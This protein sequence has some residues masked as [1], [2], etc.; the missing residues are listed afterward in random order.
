M[1]SLGM[2]GAHLDNTTVT[3]RLLPHP[4]PDIFYQANRHDQSD[5]MHQ[6]LS[7]QQS[8]CGPLLGVINAINH[9]FVMD[10]HDPLKER[11]ISRFS[12]WLKDNN[13]KDSDTSFSNTLHNT[14]LVPVFFNPVVQITALKQ[15]VYS[16]QLPAACWG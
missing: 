3:P 8:F 12:F 15:P 1:F 4:L 9:P 10:Q 14:R 7:L 13:A 11:H 6:L 5:A 2:Q 16:S